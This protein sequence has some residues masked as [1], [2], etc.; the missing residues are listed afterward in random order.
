MLSLARSAAPVKQELTEG[1]AGILAL[2]G[3]EDV[4]TRPYTS[5]LENTG[6]Q[7]LDG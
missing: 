1:A 6:D 7:S 5:K 2:H 3:E 4:D